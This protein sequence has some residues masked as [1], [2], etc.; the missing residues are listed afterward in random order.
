[1][2]AAGQ[3]L[4]SMIVHTEKSQEMLEEVNKPS[5]WIYASSKDGWFI[6][7]WF[8]MNYAVRS[9]LSN[10]LVYNNDLLKE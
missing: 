7:S 1:M 3:V 9:M 8:G 10:F 6:Q 4:P 2:N 5:S